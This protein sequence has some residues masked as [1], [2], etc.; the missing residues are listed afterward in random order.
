MYINQ[1][2][3]IGLFYLP[4]TLGIWVTFNMAVVLE[5]NRVL[6]FFGRNSLIVYIFHDILLSIMH[7][8]GS[9]MWPQIAGSNYLYPAYWHYFSFAILG[10]VPIIFICNRW[11]WF[12]FGKKHR[13]DW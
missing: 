11:F 2:G 4:A 9:K 13:D 8:I 3:N 1:Y 7:G 6:K 5:R 12:L 10:L